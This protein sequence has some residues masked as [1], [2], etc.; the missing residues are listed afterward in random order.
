[1]ENDPK[2]NPS[3][4]NFPANGGAEVNTAEADGRISLHFATLT[5]HEEVITASG[6]WRRSE[7]C[8]Q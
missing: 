5:G 4:S 1:V 6:S 3:K 8:R 2:G 7:S